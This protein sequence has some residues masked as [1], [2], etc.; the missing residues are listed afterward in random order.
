[1]DGPGQTVVYVNLLFSSIESLK[2]AL[3]LFHQAVEKP[4][5]LAKKRYVLKALREYWITGLLRS[6][7]G[8]RGRW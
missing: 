1:M 8:C 3:D 6:S 2:I 4:Q 5:S 7:A